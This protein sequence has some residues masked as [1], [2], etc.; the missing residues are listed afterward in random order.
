MESLTVGIVQAD[1]CANVYYTQARGL[2][3]AEGLDVRMQRLPGVRDRGHTGAALKETLTD[4]VIS[5]AFDFAIANVVTL[6]AARA[7]G[8]PVRFVAPAT[9]ILPRPLQIDQIMVLKESAIAPGAGCNGKTFALNR[10]HNL[11][12]P[13]AKEWVAR[14]GGDPDSIRFIEA[15]FSVMDEELRTGRADVIMATEPFTPAFAKVIG[16][17]FEVVGERFML[18]GWFA[19]DAW[20]AGHAD[21]A[22][23]FARAMSA[24]SDWAN[25]HQA[26]S[27]QI[28][29]D[30]EGTRVTVEIARNMVR[31]DYGLTLEPAMLAPL[32]DI[33]VKYGVLSA[34]IA[35]EE[36]IWTAA[37]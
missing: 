3:A 11:Q 17:P 20:L 15:A 26:E 8:I 35:P 22:A 31:A 12:E 10:L 2:F 34:P 4:P 7:A 37:G 36:L 23:A 16:N 5:G 1:P 24:G 21:L 19:A 29:A 14:Y 13:I 25:T 9:V 27:A 30:Q 33:A 18:N 28:L 6:A 32:I